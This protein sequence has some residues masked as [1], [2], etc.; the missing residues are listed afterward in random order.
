[1]TKT[2][3][4]IRLSKRG[5]TV[6]PK[7][8]RDQIGEVFSIVYDKNIGKWIIVNINNLIDQMAGSLNTG[9]TAQELKDEI[10]TEEKLKNHIKK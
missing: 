4:Q 3:Y 10:R 5:Q 1:M 8:L 7:S 9:K 2:S 6:I